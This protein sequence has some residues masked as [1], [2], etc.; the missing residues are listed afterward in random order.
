MAFALAQLAYL[1]LGLQNVGSVA[2]PLPF[3][4][5]VAVEVAASF[6]ALAGG[7]PAVLATRVR[8]FQQQGYDATVALSSAAIMTTASWIAIVVLLACSLPFAWG[9]IHLKATPQAGAGL[10]D[11][12]NVVS[13]RG[14]ACRAGRGRRV[15]RSRISCPRAAGRPARRRRGRSAPR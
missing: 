13:G 2:D 4:R 10:S 8:F 11:R 6:S 15:R 12:T 9:S 7:T 14:M 1:A 5:A 3:G